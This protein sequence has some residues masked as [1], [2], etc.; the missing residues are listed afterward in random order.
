MTWLHYANG[1]TSDNQLSAVLDLAH[2]VML[3][4]PTGG[5][6][7]ILISSIWK[8]LHHSA[9][10]A[11]AAPEMMHAMAGLQYAHLSQGSLQLL[12]AIQQ[13]LATGDDLV[14]AQLDICNAFSSISRSKT[15][16]LCRQHLSEHAT[17]CH[18]S[19]SILG[20]PLGICLPGSSFPIEA[21]STGI[22]GR[23]PQFSPFLLRL[24]QPYADSG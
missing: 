19:N 24:H 20:D 16:E 6:R 7:P 23:P 15:L 12:T 1:P 21:T 8:K 13:Q 14:V 22:P 17:G 11:K 2:L 9:L 18:G 3:S 5:I 4:K 10:A